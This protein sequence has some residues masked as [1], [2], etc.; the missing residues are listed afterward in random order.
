MRFQTTLISAA[1]LLAFG[2]ACDR[3]DAEPIEEA[4]SANTVI[5]DSPATL[6]GATSDVEG[7]CAGL[8]G[9]AV[10]DC[11]SRID[12]NA[13]PVPQPGEPNQVPGTEDNP[14]PRGD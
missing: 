10:E 13:V 8:T 6:P 4:D 14:P 1:L 2:T 5:D 9:E 11:E 7:P 12:P 3:R